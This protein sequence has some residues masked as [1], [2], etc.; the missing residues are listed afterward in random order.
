MIKPTIQWLAVVAIAASLTSC[1]GEKTTQ[2]EKS[3]DTVA[4]Q[5][6]TYEKSVETVLNEL[7]TPSQIPALLEST[8]AEYNSTLVNSLEKVSS[9]TTTTG[10]AALNLGAYTTD[11]A[12]LCVYDKAQDALSYIKTSQKLSQHIGVVQPSSGLLEKRVERNLSNRDSLISIV[13]EGVKVGDKYLKENEQHGTAAFVVVGSFI[14]GL[15]IAT[16]VA[17]K[18]PKDL[19]KDT[20]NQVLTALVRAVLDQKKP[21]KDIIV[22]LN[23]L[24]ASQEVD[25]IKKQLVELEGVFASLNMDEKIKNNKGDLVLNDEAIAPVTA[26]VKEIRTKITG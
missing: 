13:N 11:L 14:E 15:Y 8:G 10:K 23:T 20:R 24:P 21:L 2:T 25:D 5:P 1:G 19:P 12:Y 18:Y 17:E 22:M 7:P 16:G 6:A 9:Y 26:K 4:S 3:A